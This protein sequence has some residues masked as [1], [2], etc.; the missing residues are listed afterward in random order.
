MKRRLVGLAVGLVLAGCGE[1]ERDL[2]VVQYDAGSEG[3]DATTAADANEQLDPTLGGPCTEDGQCDDQIPCTADRCDQ[4][5]KRCRNTPDDGLC[6]DDVYCNGKERCVL[7]QVP[8]DR[9]HV[10][11]GGGAVGG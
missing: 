11:R 10:D 1:D 6:Q 8:L 2:F 4:T 9:G 3:G 7:R 5:L